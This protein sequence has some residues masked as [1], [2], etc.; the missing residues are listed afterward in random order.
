MSP[1]RELP[2]RANL[3]HLRNEA[4]QRL[5][6]TRRQD[7][8]AKLAD[9]QLLVARGYGFASWRA[10]KAVADGRER[11]TVFTCGTV[12]RPRCTSPP[13]AARS[14]SRGCS[15]T[16][17]PIQTSATTSTTRPCSAGPSTAPSRESP[18]CYGSAARS[19][20]RAR[21]GQR[22]QRAQRMTA[23]AGRPISPVHVA[24]HCT[25]SLCN[26]M[27]CSRRCAVSS[28]SDKPG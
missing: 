20:E 17:A 9:A 24:N 3:E 8:S 23:S 21:R 28:A 2:A 1:S 25:T 7:A 13:R 19:N 15:W 16:P 11:E 10:L 12:I 22:A 14:I 4:K 27:P 5:R 26:G 6:E 18:S